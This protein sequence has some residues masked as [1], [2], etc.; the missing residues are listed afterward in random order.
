MSELSTP[1]R[2][3]RVSLEPCERPWNAVEIDEAAQKVDLPGLVH[4]LLAGTHRGRPGAPLAIKQLAVERLLIHHH[5]A[6]RRRFRIAM[7]LTAH[8]ESVA[9]QVG[10][11]LLAGFW[12]EEGDAVIE[13]WLA[14]A[15]DDDWEVREWAAGMGAT[16]LEEDYE[17]IR[18]RFSTLIPHGSARVARAI[19]VAVRGA[20]DSRRPERVDGFLDLLEPLM[21]EEDLVVRKILGTYVLGDGVLRVYPRATLTRMKS[22]ARRTNW[23]IRWNIAMALS[24]PTA[25]QHVRRAI[26]ILKGM[27]R[28]EPQVDRA[29]MRAHNNLQAGQ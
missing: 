17:A 4:A 14:L 20:L 27:S 1:V 8:T 24:T 15:E 13:R 16:L 10:C 6:P 25:R 3:R 23:V 19:A 28:V 11:P 12:P 21:E 26:P 7:A 18:E 9:R 5:R 22:W 29:V 2:R